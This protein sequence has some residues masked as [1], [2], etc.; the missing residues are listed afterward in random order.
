MK[1]KYTKEQ[2]KEAVIKSLSI[3][4]VCRILDIRPSGGNYKTINNYLKEWNIDKSHFT[5]KAWNAGLRYKPFKK[6]KDINEILIENSTYVSSN[7]LR[8]RLISEGLKDHKCEKCN[9]KEWLDE[10]IKLE[11]HHINGL[12]LDHR[13]ENLQ[14]L[15]PN[16]HSITDNFRGKNIKASKADL[17]KSE[18]DKY[19]DFI[20]PE[21]EKENEIR[22][23]KPKAPCL[24]CQNIVKKIGRKFCS[25]ECMYKFNAQ[26]IPSKDELL[27]NLLIYKT[28]WSLGKFYKVSDVTIKKWF[29]KYNIDKKSL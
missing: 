5:G 22:I 26:N 4:E 29:K 2:L 11:L 21:F 17:R 28:Y 23:Q 15:C 18:Y 1:V 25:Y 19:K 9:L 27:K 24:I 12:N 16:C 6:I 14:L 20:N 13:I 7:A 8:K 3:A 10:P